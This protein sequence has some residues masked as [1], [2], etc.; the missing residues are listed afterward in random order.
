MLTEDVIKLDCAFSFCPPRIRRSFSRHLRLNFNEPCS[1]WQQNWKCEQICVRVCVC[2]DYGLEESWKKAAVPLDDD[3][4][5]LFSSSLISLSSLSPK[6]SA[7]LHC[8]RVVANIPHW[9]VQF[10]FLQGDSDSSPPHFTSLSF[11]SFFS[12]Y[13]FF[14]R[15]FFSISL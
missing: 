2:V 9:D 6:P 8:Y 12:E 13:L 15:F 4:S 1:T 3:L 14:Y 7:S 11:V 5:E 10:L